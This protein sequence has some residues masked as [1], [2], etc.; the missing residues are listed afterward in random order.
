MK[1]LLISLG[2]II[3]AI[4]AGV[5]V[6]IGGQLLEKYQIDDAINVVPVHLFCGIWEP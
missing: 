5:I 3:I 2:I 6:V 4:V 1:K